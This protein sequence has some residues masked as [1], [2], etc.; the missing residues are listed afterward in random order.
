MNVKKNKLR[1]YAYILDKFQDNFN[2]MERSSI[3][4]DGIQRET[5]ETNKAC[6]LDNWKSTIWF[7]GENI[8]DSR[9]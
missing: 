7:R 1:N 3:T 9:Q 5:K 4:S 8:G 2:N 6:H